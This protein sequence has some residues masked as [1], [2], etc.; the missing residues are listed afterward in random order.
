MDC[1]LVAQRDGV[2]IAMGEAELAMVDAAAVIGGFNERHSDCRCD[3]HSPGRAERRSRA[4]TGDATLE[5]DQFARNEV[6]KK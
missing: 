2:L 4:P 6:V 3:R 1:C 5:I